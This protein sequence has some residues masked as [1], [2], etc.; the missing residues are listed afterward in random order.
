MSVVRLLSMN[1]DQRNNLGMSSFSGAI[2]TPYRHPTHAI[3]RDAM[4]E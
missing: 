1:C 4:L 3:D 2:I